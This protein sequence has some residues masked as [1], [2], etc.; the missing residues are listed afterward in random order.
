[1]AS[2]H[3]LFISQYL[4]VFLRILPMRVKLIL[5]ASRFLIVLFLSRRWVRVFLVF[6]HWLLRLSPGISFCLD[7]VN[8]MILLVVV[9]GNMG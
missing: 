6:L 4:L 1:M 5:I 9:F 2:I 7:V 3:L 8:C